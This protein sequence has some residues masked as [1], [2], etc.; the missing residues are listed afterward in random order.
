MVVDFMAFVWP[1]A[2]VMQKHV[3]SITCARMNHIVN[4]AWGSRN[5]HRPAGCIC[6]S[7]LWC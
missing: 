2:R 7:K 1:V 3:D 5:S 4:S 6:L